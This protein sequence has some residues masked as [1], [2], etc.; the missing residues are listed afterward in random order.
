MVS[1]V[2]NAYMGGQIEGARPCSDH[3]LSHVNENNEASRLREEMLALRG[4]LA[5]T[6]ERLRRLEEEK[7][8]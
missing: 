8:K 3:D 1:E 6:N 4:E 2:I 5:K 7:G